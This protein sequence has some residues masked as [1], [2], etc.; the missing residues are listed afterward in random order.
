MMR[1]E[2]TSIFCENVKISI[3]GYWDDDLCYAGG[4]VKQ[5]IKATTQLTAFN[6]ITTLP[7]AT[8]FPRLQT[9]IFD[10]CLP[11]L[12]PVRVH[13]YSTDAQAA[14]LIA[15]L[16]ESFAICNTTKFAAARHLAA[17]AFPATTL[18]CPPVEFSCELCDD[19]CVFSWPDVLYD[20]KKK[21]IVDQ[22]SKPL[23]EH[24]DGECPGPIS[25]EQ[26]RKDVVSHVEMVASLPQEQQDR[27]NAA[28]WDLPSDSDSDDDGW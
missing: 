22:G 14:D 23:L 16:V 27:M 6:C 17:A 24:E 7:S 15:D 18:V 25:L 3:L 13:E 26:L 10:F 12:I 1:N 8:M 4:I 20:A 5:Y 28:P 19:S 9:L 2:A 11:K 21:A